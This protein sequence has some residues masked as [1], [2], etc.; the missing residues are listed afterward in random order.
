[1]ADSVKKPLDY[2][3][4]NTANS[5]ALIEAAVKNGAAYPRL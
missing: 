1:L 5:R 4:N 2:S 3:K